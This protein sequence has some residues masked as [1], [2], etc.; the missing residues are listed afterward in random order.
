MP[1]VGP[2]LGAQ[3]SSGG[4]VGSRFMIEL[5][6]KTLRGTLIF[7]TSGAAPDRRLNI[8][9]RV[10]GNTTVLVF[11]GYRADDLVNVHGKRRPRPRGER[12]VVGRSVLGSLANIG[13]GTRLV[14]DGAVDFQTNAHFAPGEE[15]AMSCS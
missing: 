7:A 5:D 11:A 14:F 13:T 9:G 15:R 2:P 12:L 10:A 4:K 3:C 1:R 6:P 8:V